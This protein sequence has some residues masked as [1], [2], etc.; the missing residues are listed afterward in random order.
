MAFCVPFSFQDS[1]HTSLSFLLTLISGTLSPTTSPF[2]YP[3]PKCR[4]YNGTRPVTIYQ[5]DENDLSSYDAG[6]RV[7][8]H[9]QIFK[10]RGWPYS[11]WCK[12]SAYQPLESSYWDEAWVRAGTCNSAFAPTVSPSSS[13]TSNP[14][15]TPITRINMDSAL[16]L[17]YNC[18]QLNATTL[19]QIAQAIE[20][21]T[22]LNMDPNL[23]NG[24]TLES[25]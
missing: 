16:G 6:T 15:V 8:I 17:Q 7:R 1:V 18:S 11:L 4:W 12:M 5:W 21:A 2:V 24:E 25:V 13:P 20:E 9:D 10:C 3:D 23:G 22:F 19:L 14:T